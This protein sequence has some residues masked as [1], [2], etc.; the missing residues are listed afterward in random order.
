[1]NKL[2]L[3]S[4]LLCFALSC[5]LSACQKTQTKPASTSTDSTVTQQPGTL[6]IN[7]NSLTLAGTPN[8]DTVTITTTLFWKATPS[9]SWIHLDTTQGTGSWQLVISADTNFTGAVQTGSVTL[10]P[11]SNSSAVSLNITVKQNT[12]NGWK[13]LSDNTAGLSTNAQPSLVYTYNGNLYFGSVLSSAIRCI[14]AAARC[15]GSI[16]QMTTSSIA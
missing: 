3:F 7:N 15:W 2:P 4:I 16:R 11:F 10:T 13:Q 9:A 1:M 12:F 6:Q 14:S 5:A 8:S